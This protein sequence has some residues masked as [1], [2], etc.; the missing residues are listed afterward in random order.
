[1]LAHHFISE[2]RGWSL[3]FLRPCFT[4]CELSSFWLGIFLSLSCQHDVYW[5]ALLP[6]LAII[7]RQHEYDVY[8]FALR[9]LSL[10]RSSSAILFL[11]F[12]FRG[13]AKR[14]SV[15]PA[16]LI[17]VARTW[18]LTA[19]AW[20]ARRICKLGCAYAHCAFQI[21]LTFLSVTE[22]VPQTHIVI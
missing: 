21:S 9:A 3:A 7:P 22:V 19:L 12:L 17:A 11:C 18:T 4:E 1:M 10:L 16:P 14:Q 5:G 8:V 6:R 15:R 13:V 2:A 20:A